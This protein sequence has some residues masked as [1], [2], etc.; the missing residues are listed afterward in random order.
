MRIIIFIRWNGDFNHN[1]HGPKSNVPFFFF[2]IF[3][4]CE[5]PKKDIYLSGDS[6]PK[7][8]IKNNRIG[9][10]MFHKQKK[11]KKKEREIDKYRKNNTSLNGFNE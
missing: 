2:I 6:E 10:Q 5:I 8:S 1:P 9:T 11:K 7:V 4:L 3:E